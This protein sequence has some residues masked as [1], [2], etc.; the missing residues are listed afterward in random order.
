VSG[1]MR[2]RVPLLILPHILPDLPVFFI[3]AEKPII[4][5]PL[6]VQL[7]KFATRLIFDSEC[8]E[9]LPEF[10]NDLLTLHAH[11]ACTDVADLNWA[12]TE[13]WRDAL[14]T[15]FYPA[16]KF[17]DLKEATEIKITF[18]AAST[19]FFCHTNIQALYLQIWLASRLNWKFKS[20]QKTKEA[21]VFIYT[22][23]DGEVVIS[24][25]F[26]QEARLA[27]GIVVSLDITSKNGTHYAFSRDLKKPH[28][29]KLSYSTRELCEMP[30]YFL[31]A[32]GE[33][34]QSLVKEISHKGTSQH[35]L[36]VLERVS[37]LDTK[38]LC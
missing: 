19:A 38:N 9:S 29:I 10:A 14:S 21:L 25:T 17:A 27:P 32:K 24:L 34:G 7:S 12:R 6:F 35:Y 37:K 11:A 31:F 3:W 1:E 36:A 22:R 2:M 18:N 13:N 16:Q 33:K 23:E 4:T 8:S 15:T 5:D 26:T 20:G 28:Q 30:A